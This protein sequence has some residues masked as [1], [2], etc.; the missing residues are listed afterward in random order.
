MGKTLLFRTLFA[1]NQKAKDF[2]REYAKEHGEMPTAEQVSEEKA[3]SAEERAEL[4]N[5]M[6]VSSA[7]VNSSVEV[8]AVWDYVWNEET[9]NA[10][11]NKENSSLKTYL[12]MYPDEDRWNEHENRPA[13][14]RDKNPDG[15]WPEWCPQCWRGAVNA[16]GAQYPWCVVNVTPFVGCIKFNYD[17]GEDVL[18]WGAFRNFKSN[19]AIASI[20]VELGEEYKLD[21]H[22]QTTF[23]PAKL[24]VTI[25]RA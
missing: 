7:V 23:E 2:I 3:L 10:A 19:F 22:G 20:P 5:S 12:D 6:E 13:Q 21:E 25:V 17:G 4:Q 18:P 15:T 14:G 9:W 11:Y 8:P 16:P 1:E 24:A